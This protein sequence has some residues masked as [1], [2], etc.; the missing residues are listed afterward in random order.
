[1]PEEKRNDGARLAQLIA[2]KDI[3]HATFYS[4]MAQFGYASR[5][6]QGKFISAQTKVIPKNDLCLI[7]SILGFRPEDFDYPPNYFKSSYSNKEA[8]L[9]CYNNRKEGDK[10]YRPFVERFFEEVNIYL[11]KVEEELLVCDYLDKVR[12]IERKENMIY[13]HQ[14]NTEYYESI[15]KHFAQKME[16]HPGKSI[17]YKRLIQIP[18]GAKVDHLEEAIEFVIEEMFAESFAHLCR[19]LRD[20]KKQCEFYVVIKPFRLHTYYLVD[21][22]VALTEYHRYDKKGTPIPDTLFVNISDPG[23]EE[24][25]GSIYLRSCLDEFERMKNANLSARLTVPN[26]LNGVISLETKIKN[27]IEALKS[28]IQA[29]VQPAY[30]QEIVRYVEDTIQGKVHKIPENL[31]NHLKDWEDQE[32]KLNLMRERRK[33]I[34]EKMKIISD[35]IQGNL[36]N[37]I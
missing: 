30:Q 21:G 22:K 37:S 11:L 35:T 4:L 1:M 32:K 29:S 8:A 13:Y 36:M 33:S 6:T 3:N 25:V 2:Q 26:M 19:C 24:A 5:A 12:G 20:F 31:V 7:C 15:E 9:F 17:R 10:A 18:L 34:H 27:E 14:H 16:R 28:A 23:D